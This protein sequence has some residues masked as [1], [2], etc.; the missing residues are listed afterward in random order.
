MNTVHKS[1]RFHELDILR[2]LAAL[3]VVFFHYTFLN[4]TE[5]QTL[6]SYP[7]LGE[8]FKYGY[9]GVELFFIISGFVILLT[10]SKKDWQGFVIS[11]LARLYPAFWIAVTLTS[12]GIVLFASDVMSVTLPQYLINLTMMGEFVGVR[13]I[14]PVY[15][16]LQI[17]LKFYFWILVILLFN[18]IKYI[19][20][21]ITIWLV[22]AFLEIY[23]L[24]HEFTHF[25][26]IP[27]WAPYFSAGALFY[28]IQTQGINLK[29]A[30]LLVIAYFLSMY[31]ALEGAEARSQLYGTEF[32]PIITLGL[33][34]LFYGL[35]TLII[36]GK[37]TRLYHP[38]FTLLG[39]TTYPLY[40]IHQKLGQIAYLIVGDSINKYL[41]LFLIVI[42]MIVIAYLLHRYFEAGFGKGIKRKLESWRGSGKR[43]NS[44]I[45]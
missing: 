20:S 45:N 40:L 27:E 44:A 1:Q 39:A 30:G 5:Y 6:P 7:V 14:D 11:R 25:A 21:F 23:H 31:F 38:W 2:F 29:R 36:M 35:F 24:G 22:I 3:A 42:S 9:L 43:S 33:I 4:I 19:E 18:K 28:I 16:T 12:L 41:F 17:E 13:N 8:I 32:S 10:A 26:F 34:T 37:T 15:W